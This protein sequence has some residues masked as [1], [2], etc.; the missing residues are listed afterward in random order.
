MNR[1]VR[2]LSVIVVVALVGCGVNAASGIV[3]TWVSQ[4]GSSIEIASDGKWIGHMGPMSLNLTYSVT[5]S[6]GKLT[7]IL[8]KN[9]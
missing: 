3:G 7:D 8:L 5:K 4:S 9:A 6:D 1:S 2:L